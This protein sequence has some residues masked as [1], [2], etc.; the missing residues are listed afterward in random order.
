MWFFVSE[1]TSMTKST[2]ADLIERTGYRRF[3]HSI[4]WH[5]WP[6]IYGGG[7]RGDCSR[8]RASRWII[9]FTG[10]FVVFV[11]GGGGG[12]IK[13]ALAAIFAK[14]V[15]GDTLTTTARRRSQRWF[16]HCTRK[17]LQRLS[18]LGTLNWAL[19][20]ET[21]KMTHRFSNDS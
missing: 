2:H 1:A 12:G 16:D 5:V 19:G 18:E 7:G 8:C 20:S 17:R 6:C 15:R 13:T 11:R 4:V 10:C 3:Q 9:F 14:S 21:A